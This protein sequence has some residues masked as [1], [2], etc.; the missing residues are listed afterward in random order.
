MKR[1]EHLSEEKSGR[2]V[3]FHC[4]APDSFKCLNQKCRTWPGAFFDNTIDDLKGDGDYNG[5]P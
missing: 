1:C 4:A 3:V 2:W 5:S